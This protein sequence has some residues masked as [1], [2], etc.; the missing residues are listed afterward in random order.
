MVWYSYDK[1]WDYEIYMTTIPEMN[2]FPSISFGG[3]A[4]LAGL[5]LGIV[6]WARRGRLIRM[7]RVA[8]A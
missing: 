7:R 4:L 2:P 3:L 8:T 6:A 5:V 1:Y